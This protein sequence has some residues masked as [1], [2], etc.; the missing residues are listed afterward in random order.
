MLDYGLVHTWFTHT[1]HKFNVQWMLISFVWLYMFKCDVCVLNHIWIKSKRFLFFLFAFGSDLYHPCFS[2]FSKLILC[3]KHVFSVFSQLIL[4]V[5][6]VASLDREFRECFASILRVIHKK[7]LPA[8][9]PSYPWKFLATCEI[10][11]ISFL[12]GISRDICF[13]LFPSSPKP[14]F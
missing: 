1:T 13:K 6:L 3:E 4:R 7:G 12:K 14:L 2:K 8:K 9:I 5:N 10:F 11:Q